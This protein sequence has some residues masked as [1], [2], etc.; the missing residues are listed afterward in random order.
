MAEG[1]S[2]IKTAAKYAGISER[3][4]RGWLKQGLKHSR[5]PSGLLL[6]SYTAIDEFLE[7]FT[8]DSNQVDEITEEILKGIITG[9]NVKKI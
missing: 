3:T 4:F 9:N 5:L 2:K 6:I 7:R 8:A 1:W